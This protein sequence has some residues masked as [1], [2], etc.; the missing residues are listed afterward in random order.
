MGYQQ[1]PDGNV[2]W[3]PLPG[4][5]PTP[6]VPTGGGGTTGTS[7][8]FALPSINLTPTEITDAQG[9]VYYHDPATGQTRPAIDADGQQV[10]RHRRP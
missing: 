4:E 6:P 5:P 7:G 3:V 10:Q 1:D 8:G 2:I 9:R